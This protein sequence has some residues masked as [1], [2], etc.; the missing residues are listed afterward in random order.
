MRGFARE[1]GF[2]VLAPVFGDDHIADGQR[3]IDAARNTGKDDAFDGEAVEHQLGGHGR[4]DFADAA[5]H[6]HDRLAVERAGEKRH[7][8]DGVSVRALHC[9]FERG[10]FGAEGGHDDGARGF[11]EL[12]RQRGGGDGAR[13]GS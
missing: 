2:E 7:A 10:V 13:D 9:A 5:F 12:L 11:I 1:R 3:G 6:Q 4:V 8:V